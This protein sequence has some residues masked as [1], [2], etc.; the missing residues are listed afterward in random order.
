[1]LL[2]WFCPLLLL[3]ELDLQRP[4][5]CPNLHISYIQLWVKCTAVLRSNI[6][7]FCENPVIKSKN[8]RLCGLSLKNT[9]SKGLPVDSSNCW[10]LTASRWYSNKVAYILLWNVAQNTWYNTQ[11]CYIKSWDRR[12]EFMAREEA[13]S[14]ITFASRGVTN[15]TETEFLP[16]FKAQHTMCK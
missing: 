3:Q 10:D 14:R 6:N 11:S 8:A 2:W 16:T 7:F 9:I 13:L 12:F 1:M 4:F 15:L 5:T